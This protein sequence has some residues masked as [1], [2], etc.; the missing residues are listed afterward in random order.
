MRS[1]RGSITPKGASVDEGIGLD[2]HYLYLFDLDDRSLS[3]FT[4][5]SAPVPAFGRVV[6]DRNGVATPSRL[7]TVEE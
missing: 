7:P 3:V 5:S 6:F 2:T 1:F 4:S